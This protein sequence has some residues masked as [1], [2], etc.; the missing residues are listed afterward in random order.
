MFSHG[1]GDN[2]GFQ[3]IRLSFSED[4]TAVEHPRTLQPI[5]R[6]SS[7]QVKSLIMRFNSTSENHAID[8]Q[9]N[10]FMCQKPIIAV[11][12]VPVRPN[13]PISHSDPSFKSSGIP[14]HQTNAAGSCARKISGA[15]GEGVETDCRSEL[16]LL[17]PAELGPGLPNDDGFALLITDDRDCLTSMSSDSDISSRPLTLNFTDGSRHLPKPSM[18]RRALTPQLRSV[19]EI[20]AEGNLMSNPSTVGGL[21]FLLAPV[22]ACL[23]LS[24]LTST[25]LFPLFTFAR[26]GGWL[27][28][29]LPQWLFAV[30]MVSDIFG[31]VLAKQLSHTSIFSL[32]VRF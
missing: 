19:S 4:R 13:Q 1:T 26:S 8:P 16:P 10:L 21:I 12:L 3:N 14:Y 25:L 11:K 18:D 31:R 6:E 30:R 7:T 23:F 9:T 29:R 22:L 15:V 28:E 20:D 2:G 24:V 5:Q 32:Q 17:L 27:G